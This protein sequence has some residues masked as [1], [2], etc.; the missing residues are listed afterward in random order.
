MAFR[1]A[2]LSN[3]LFSTTTVTSMLLKDKAFIDN[4]WVNG[5]NGKT[6]EVINPGNGALINNVPD[7]DV[8]DVQKAITAARA[9]FLT[10]RDTTAKQRSDM[11]KRWHALLEKNKDE[12]SKILTLE[13]GK[14]LIEAQA[15][16]HYGNS[17][18][19]WFA[20]EARRS[21]G[22]IVP[23]PVSTKKLFVEKEP[24]GVIGI[25]TPWNF[26]LAMITRKAA[27]AIACGCTCVIKPAEDTPLTALAIAELTIEAGFPKGVFNV[28]TSSANNAPEI[29]K[30]FCESPL[31][32]GVSFTGSTMVGKILYQ[33]SA[34][35]LKRLA[36]ELGG[37]AP[38]IV[39]NSANIENAV[40]CAMGAK[41]R[42]A[43][44]TCIGA[45][46]FLVQEKIHDEFI[47]KF[48]EAIKKIKI[49]DGMKEGV[50]LGP[51]I[52]KKQFDRI[53]KLVEDTKNEGGKIILGGNA[54][55]NIGELFYEPTVIVDVTREMKIY[56]EEI[57]GPVVSVVKFKTENEATFLA[58][59][60]RSGLA[61]YI[62]TEDTAQMQR[63]S[64]TMEVGILG[65][66]EGLIST[67]EA[68]FGGVKESGLGREG[69][70]YGMHEFENIKYVCLGNL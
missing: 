40:K 67:A 29:G 18:V 4:E 19:E 34:Q 56:H 32:A 30:L 59:D 70:H 62:F 42:N 1:L 48:C 17:F 38:F 63:F 39:F 16:L 26:P 5:H 7:L 15:E 36:L 8:N 21:R 69:S 9:A 55:K 20:E 14:P 61:G 33:Q 28:I 44:Q 46:R 66:N 27:T 3:R 50:T 23:S 54:L 43:G 10:Y 68:P 2:L 12:L 65:I 51:I 53:A 58:N 13:S 49:G 60:T 41:F 52:N 31:I 64:K 11:L 24:L 57:F 45:N 35:T 47:S 37:N 6:F 22:D 25:I